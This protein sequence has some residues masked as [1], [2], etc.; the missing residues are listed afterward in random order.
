[1]VN[2]ALI[3]QSTAVGFVERNLLDVEFIQVNTN[4]GVAATVYEGCGWLKLS[5]NHD[6]FGHPLQVFDVLPRAEARYKNNL[7]TDLE[8]G[9]LLSV[10][11]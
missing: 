6:H 10:S 3:F 11:P 1:M 8:L 5:G 4:G 7:T 2:R 9:L